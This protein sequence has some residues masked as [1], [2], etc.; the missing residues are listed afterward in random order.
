MLIRS[1]PVDL[2]MGEVIQY[3]IDRQRPTG[4]TTSLSTQKTLANATFTEA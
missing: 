4:S 2:K 3:A 1:L